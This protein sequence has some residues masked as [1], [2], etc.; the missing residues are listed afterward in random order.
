M[1]CHKIVLT[2]ITAL[3]GLPLQVNASHVTLGTA[4]N[5]WVRGGSTVTNAGLTVFAD[6]GARHRRASSVRGRDETVS[7]IANGQ[8]I[9]RLRRVAF[10]SLTQSTD[11]LIGGTRVQIS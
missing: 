10:E 7:R 4:G 9:L 8:K 3:I 6:A 5:F 11:E 1:R 2:A